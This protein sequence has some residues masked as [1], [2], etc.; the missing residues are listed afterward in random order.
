MLRIVLTVLV[1]IGTIALIWVLWQPITWIVIAAFVAVALAG[2]VNLLARAMPR[3]LAIALVY[4]ALL[5]VPIG[6][7]AAV[8]PPIVDQGV[9]FVNDLP[10]Y[11]DDLQAEVQKN[12][13]LTEFDDDFGVTTELNRVAQD[14]PTK[15]GE[16]ATIIRDF[17]SGLVSSLF[18]GLTI[19]ILSIFMVARGRKWRSTESATLSATTSL[20]PSCKQQ[21]LE[22]A[23]SSS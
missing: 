23:L 20:A 4:I 22:S 21:S 10:G 15:I 5:L 19:Y 17:G 6:I 13:K 16:A 18:A 2:P 3:P 9:S 7:S 11:V 1:V 14:A 8:L 12:P